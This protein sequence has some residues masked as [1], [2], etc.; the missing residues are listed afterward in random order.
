MAGSMTKLS[1][2]FIC[3]MVVLFSLF[4]TSEANYK[5]AP[6]NGI[7]FGKRGYSGKFKQKYPL[8]IL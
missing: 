2:L 5:N 6:M 7:M 8:V 1:V 4:E 3:L